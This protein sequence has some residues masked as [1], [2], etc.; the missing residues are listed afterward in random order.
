MRRLANPDGTIIVERLVTFDQPGRRYTYVIQQ[1]PFPVT[2]YLSTLCVR[3]TGTGNGSRVEWSGRFTPT[4]V[5]TA[6]AAK[7]F[8]GIY[9]DGL[10]ALAARLAATAP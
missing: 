5:S 9:E 4:G 3:E 2:N 10:K 1:A 7:L 6:D 8:R